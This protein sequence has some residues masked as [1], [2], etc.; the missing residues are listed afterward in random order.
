MKEII[1]YD[2]LSPIPDDAIYMCSRDEPTGWNGGTE[3]IHYFLVPV[4]PK[5]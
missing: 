5:T 4:E 1:V 3:V 2:G